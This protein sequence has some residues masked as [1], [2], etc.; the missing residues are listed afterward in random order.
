MWIK[1]GTRGDYRIIYV[2][3]AF[4]VFLGLRSE[5]YSLYELNGGAEKGVIIDSELNTIMPTDN[6]NHNS[7][8][9]L[10]SSKIN[11]HLG[12]A[13]DCEK[14]FHTA[15]NREQVKNLYENN[16]IGNG[17]KKVNDN[18][19]FVKESMQMKFKFVDESEYYSNERVAPK[20]LRGRT[21]FRIRI[22]IK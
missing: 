20:H 14:T 9:R 18:E 7:I 8:V 17:W 3:I 10:Q 5:Y 11:K 13:R 21:I 19:D 15:L 2:I 12:G 1:V 6:R 16:A 22:E 4:L